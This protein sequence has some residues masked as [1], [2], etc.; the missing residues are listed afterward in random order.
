MHRLSIWVCCIVLAG[1][2]ADVKPTTPSKV[3]VTRHADFVELRL[4]QVVSKVQVVNSEPPLTMMV[5]VDE[6]EQ[7]T[8]VSRTEH[9]CE[10]HVSTLKYLAVFNDDKVMLDELEPDIVVEVSPGTIGEAEAQL[11]CTTNEGLI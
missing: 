4:K 5:T 10:A 8:Y 2:E 6:A 7:T 11:A 9:D 3:Q 1:C